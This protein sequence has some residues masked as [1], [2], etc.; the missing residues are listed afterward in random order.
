MAGFKTKIKTVKLDFSSQVQ[1]Q[2]KLTEAH[3]T[4]ADI[5]D[6]SKHSSVR[7]V[8]EEIIDGKRFKVLTVG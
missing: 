7:V 3:M 6:T 4:G 2:E 1:Q 5:G 8:R